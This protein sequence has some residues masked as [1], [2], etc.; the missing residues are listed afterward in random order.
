MILFFPL[1]KHSTWVA[2]LILSINKD[3]IPAM[4]R[5][6]DRA[7]PSPSEILKYLSKSKLRLG[8]MFF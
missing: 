1:M 6:C 5:Y 3:D 4:S 7:G 2:A 8:P